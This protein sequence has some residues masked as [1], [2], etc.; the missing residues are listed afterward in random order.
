MNKPEPCQYR[1]IIKTE[2]GLH[3]TGNEMKN[4]IVRAVPKSNGEIVET[5]KI[6]NIYTHIYDR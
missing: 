1:T 4:G 3:R 6:D 2:Y 5:C